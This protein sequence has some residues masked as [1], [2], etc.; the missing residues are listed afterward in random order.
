MAY[1]S[2]RM[3]RRT[4]SL[5]STFSNM[6]DSFVRIGHWPWQTW[7]ER[8]DRDCSRSGQH[9]SVVWCRHAAQRILNP[10]MI[11]RGCQHAE[12]GML[13]PHDVRRQIGLCFFSCLPYYVG[14]AIRVVE[15]L[16]C[17]DGIRFVRRSHVL[18]ETFCEAP[19]GGCFG[20]DFSVAP[21]VPGDERHEHDRLWSRLAGD[22][23]RRP[24]NRRQRHRHEYQPCGALRMPRPRTRHRQQLPQA[25][26]APQRPSRQ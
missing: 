12:H 19:A 25:R 7:P 3:E 4:A 10:Y 6:R 5:T 23:G 18:P 13:A 15:G 22:G 26:P 8:I 1:F 2:V 16:F 9:R 20:D 17:R 24:G 14:G 21:A 11:G